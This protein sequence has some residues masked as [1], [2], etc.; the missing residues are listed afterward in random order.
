MF[1]RQ[2]AYTIYHT[3]DEYYKNY[4]IIKLNSKYSIRRLKN[5][6]LVISYKSGFVSLSSIIRLMFNDQ[7][8]VIPK[9][10]EPRNLLKNWYEKYKKDEAIEEE[11][12]G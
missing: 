5:G 10:T 7:K 1:D 3:I 8:R 11:Y 12:Y 6:I 2:K 4:G 9:Y